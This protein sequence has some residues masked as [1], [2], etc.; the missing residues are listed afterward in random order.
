MLLYSLMHIHIHCR[1]QLL[2]GSCL[3]A[4]D[5]YDVLHVLGSKLILSVHTVNK[6]H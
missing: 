6:M 3:N 2:K 1:A 4:Y 5:N